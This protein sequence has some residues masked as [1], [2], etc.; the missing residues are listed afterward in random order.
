MQCNRCHKEL[1]AGQWQ[2]CP[3]CG[4]QI[5]FSSSSSKAKSLAA[6]VIKS[7]QRSQV[8]EVIVRQALAGA[9]WREI[10]SG[11][12]KDNG[13]TP[14]EVES[15]VERR[16]QSGTLTAKPIALTVFTLVVVLLLFELIVL[17][18]K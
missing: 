6:L 15:E 11:P 17:Y 1:E 10:C 13:I 12:M 9:P 18:Y 5:D 16:K 7:A 8:L 14:E 3:F 2:F 4:V